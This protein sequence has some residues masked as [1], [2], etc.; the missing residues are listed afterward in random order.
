ML[1][2]F[3]NRCGVT[4]GPNGRHLAPHRHTVPGPA[5]TANIP[6]HDHDYTNDF[7]AIKNARAWVTAKRRLPYQESQDEVDLSSPAG[8]TLWKSALWK[9]PREPVRYARHRTVF[10]L[11]TLFQDMARVT[12]QEL[13]WRHLEDDVVVR[14][15]LARGILSLRRGARELIETN[16]WDVTEDAVVS[17]LRRWPGG[18]PDQE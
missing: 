2:E 6:H 12:V 3:A 7:R 11:T 1:G 9:R 17:A 5:Q 15:A 13:V 4:G 14:R 10:R 16:G 8:S 18:E